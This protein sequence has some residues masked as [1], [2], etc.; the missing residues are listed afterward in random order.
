MPNKDNPNTDSMLF[1]CLAI[2]PRVRKATGAELVIAGHG[3][4]VALADLVVDGVRVV[5]HQENLTELYNRARVFV[6]PTRYA[7]GIPYKALEGAAFGVPLVVSTLIAGQLGWKDQ[8]DCLVA[9]SPGA[10]S[11]ECCRLYEDRDLWNRIRSNA[12]TRVN[13][14]AT[15]E[16]FTYAISSLIADVSSTPERQGR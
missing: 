6:V 13:N 1:F 2:W 4:D 7:A 3:S 16:A 14:E 12:L 8:E 15:D 11:E 5:G 9:G 10:F